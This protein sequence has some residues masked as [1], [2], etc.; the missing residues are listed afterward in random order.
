MPKCITDDLEFSSDE[1]TSDE[2]NCT[3]KNYMKN[4]LLKNKLNIVMS[5][6]K[7]LF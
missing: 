6:L 7:K 4:I 5:F 2:E 1:E 3:E